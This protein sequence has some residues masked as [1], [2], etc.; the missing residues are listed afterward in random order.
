MLTVD[1]A[2][3]YLAAQEEKGSEHQTEN[4]QQQRL[5]LVLIAW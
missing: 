4:L 1:V 2:E 5:V 3:M